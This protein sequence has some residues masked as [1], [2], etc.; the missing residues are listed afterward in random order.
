MSQ[1]KID[2]ILDENFKQ[3]DEKDKDYPIFK[4][5]L[6]YLKNHLLTATKNSNLSSFIKPKTMDGIEMYKKLVYILH[7]QQ[8]TNTEQ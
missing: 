6:D 7:G 4:I 5:K 3:P 1:E 8:H 2:E